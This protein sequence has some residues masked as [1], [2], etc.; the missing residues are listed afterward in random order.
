MPAPVVKIEGL[1]AEVARQKGLKDSLIAL[2]NGIGPRVQAAVTKALEEDDAADQGSV[3]VANAAIDQA[4]TDIKS[5][6]D[7]FAAALANNPS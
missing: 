7:E 6:N 4:M 1:I 2:V 5:N 3:D